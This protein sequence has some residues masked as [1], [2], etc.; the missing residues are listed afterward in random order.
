VSGYTYL[1]DRLTDPHL[2]G[3]PCDAVRRAD[4]KC[5]RGRMGTMLVRFAS[6]ETQNVVA[7]QLRRT[8]AEAAP[9][10][11]PAAGESEE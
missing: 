4:G 7:R 5:I 8:A 6:G 11:A 9:T 3:Q 10:P 1:G 2:K